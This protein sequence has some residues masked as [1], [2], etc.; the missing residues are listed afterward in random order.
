MTQPKM[1]ALLAKLNSDEEFRQLYCQAK[2][3]EERDAIFDAAVGSPIGGAERLDESELESVTGGSQSFF[4]CMAVCFDC[5][6]RSDIGKPETVC[7]W[8]K[9][10]L[11][12]SKSCSGFEVIGR[13][14]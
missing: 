6:W 14:E 9:E 5:N 2:S 13:Y 10:H 1:E 8:G 11:V 12:S 7:R 4:R 3:D